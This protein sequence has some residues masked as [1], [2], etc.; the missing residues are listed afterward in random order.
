MGW[1]SILEWGGGTDSIS[2]I[3]YLV[4]P[5]GWVIKILKTK[6]G[7]EA[8]RGPWADLFGRYNVDDQVTFKLLVAYI[9]NKFYP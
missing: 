4:Q 3:H 8:L 9:R 7:A 2:A 6:L 1:P 5:M